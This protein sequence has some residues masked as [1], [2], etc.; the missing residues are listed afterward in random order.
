MTGLAGFKQMV[1]TPMAPDQAVLQ[2]LRSD[3]QQ[4]SAHPSERNASWMLLAKRRGQSDRERHVS[5]PPAL[6]YRH[7]TFPVGALHA[8][9]LVTEGPVAPEQLAR[10]TE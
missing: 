1:E 8:K 5:K 2:V 7:V 6:R 3:C 10:R 4:I 9:L